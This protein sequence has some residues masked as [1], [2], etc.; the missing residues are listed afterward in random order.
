MLCNLFD[1][2][3]VGLQR[4]SACLSVRV[5]VCL[6]PSVSYVFIALNCLG[7]HNPARFLGH[8]LSH[9]HTHC[10]LLLKSYAFVMHLKYFRLAELLLT[11]ALFLSF[12]VVSLSLVELQ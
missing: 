3:C 4:V 8:T 12:S 2:D 6:Y 11:S 7:L 9:T 5:C 10:A 1:C